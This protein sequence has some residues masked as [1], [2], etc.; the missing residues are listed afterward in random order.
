MR[1]PLRRP[2]VPKWFTE[3]FTGL[4]CVGSK[5]I[6]HQYGDASY[7]FIKLYSADLS[8]KV[9]ECEPPVGG[10]AATNASILFHHPGS[11]NS[12]YCQNFGTRMLTSQKQLCVQ[13]HKRCSQYQTI[14]PIEKT[15]MAGHKMP[16]VFY[17]CHT[18]KLAFQQVAQCA[19]DSGDG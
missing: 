7:L 17:T 15:A 14:E 9:H 8:T 19:N 11:K 12:S 6:H 1:Q 16:T 4:W 5:V 13:P 10:R 2:L 18:F 3:L